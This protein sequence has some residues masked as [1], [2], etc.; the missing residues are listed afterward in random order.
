M[1]IM[2]KKFGEDLVW[3]QGL[4]QFKTKPNQIKKLLDKWE[5]V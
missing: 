4:Y 5:I 3:E 2:I 1:K